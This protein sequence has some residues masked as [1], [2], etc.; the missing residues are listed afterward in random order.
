MKWMRVFKRQREAEGE[1]D[2]DSACISWE[3]SSPISPELALVCC[4]CHHSTFSGLV[5]RLPEQTRSAHTHTHTHSYL[6]AS[7]K[8]QGP[9][10]N[11]LP[12][13]LRPPF[14]ALPLP[15]SNPCAAGG[16]GFTSTCEC[17]SLYG[18]VCL[19]E[20]E[21]RSGVSAGCLGAERMMMGWPLVNVSPKK[22]WRTWKP[23][24]SSIL[25]HLVS[26]TE[27]L[28]GEQVSHGVTWAN[29]VKHVEEL[30]LQ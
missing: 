18:C 3:R 16:G 20:T 14:P 2:S 19:K 15:R 12:L 25:C 13:T 30:P 22:T 9:S 8:A 1:R 7:S 21:Q 6:C 28:W 17:V 24:R 29:Y 4:S 10:R 27:V 11:K 23:N 5:W 26:F